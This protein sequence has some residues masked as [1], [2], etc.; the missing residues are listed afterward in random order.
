M[1]N[2]GRDAKRAEKRR[3]FTKKG[4]ILRKWGL[5]INALQKKCTQENNT[6]EEE[7]VLKK[8]IREAGYKKKGWG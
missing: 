4:G 2:P 1:A 8:R 7:V 6:T 5:G 3:G